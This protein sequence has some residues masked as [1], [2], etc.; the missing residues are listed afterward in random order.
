MRITRNYINEATRDGNIEKIKSLGMS[1]LN[2]DITDSLSDFKTFQY[3]LVRIFQE[4][5][6]EE[7]AS[8]MFNKLHSLNSSSRSA[9]IGELAKRYIRTAELGCVFTFKNYLDKF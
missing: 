9:A 4:E 8:S 7:I 5:V 1:Q 6:T 2:N 3:L